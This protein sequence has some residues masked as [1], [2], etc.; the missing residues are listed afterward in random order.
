MPG[1]RVNNHLDKFLLYVSVMLI[2]TFIQQ[3]FILMPELQNF[4]LIGE[5]SKVRMLESWQKWRW[6]SFFIAPIL[7]TLRLW[8]VSLC[9]FIGSFFFA[10]MSGRKFSDWWGV[11]MNVQAIMILYSIVLCIVNISAGSNAT[12]EVTKYTSL[13]FLDGDNLEQW[14][15]IPLS[16]INLIEIAYWIMMAWCVSVLTGC[17]LCKSFKFVMSSYGTGY[18]FYIILLMFLTLYLR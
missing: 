16:A 17:G 7:L 14:I 1:T 10:E 12:F 8:L 11:A 5:D 3:E 18:L 4:D 9:L 6:V 13:L 15:R 2:I